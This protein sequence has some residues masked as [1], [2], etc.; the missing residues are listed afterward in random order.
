MENTTRQN[1]NKVFEVKQLIGESEFA[2]VHSQLRQKPH[3]RGAVV[4]Y[5]FRIEN[6]RIVE[7]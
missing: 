4:V 2:A 3:D 1:S 7:L 5:I 6:G